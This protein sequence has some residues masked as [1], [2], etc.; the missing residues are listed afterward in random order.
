MSFFNKK[1]E[2]I[3]LQLT[4]FGKTLL[5]KGKFKPAYYQF[6]DDNIIY[7]SNYAGFLESQNSSA[8]RIKDN[9][10]QKTQYIF[11]GAETKMTQ[12]NERVAR[13]EVGLY[14]PNDSIPDNEERQNAL[15][16]ALHESEMGNQ[17]SPY[18]HIL[19]HGANLTG[20]L[21]HF[22]GSNVS[23]P[24][25]QLQCVAEF[26]VVKDMIL[27]PGTIEEYQLSN[28]PTD[29][30]LVFADG[31]IYSVFGEHIMF[32]FDEFN[33]SSHGD[34]FEIEV[35]EIVSGSAP[36]EEILLPLFADH[37]HE[38]MDVRN[39][40]EILTDGRIPA[41]AQVSSEMSLR[42]MFTGE[43]RDV[44]EEGADYDIYGELFSD[45]EDCE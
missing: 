24:I 1:E 30:T 28:D 32:T 39:Y 22:S 40:F 45:P 35:Y 3:D 37:T 23:H 13:G 44:D 19:A 43:A 16:Y 7:D 12:F 21:T 17:K 9:S 6:F 36:D 2:V 5:S 25:P 27:N 11:K 20:S 10:Y 14:E 31:T 41:N 34:N 18:F 42:G 38:V 4:Q 33:V 8:A 26:N 15:R 29:P